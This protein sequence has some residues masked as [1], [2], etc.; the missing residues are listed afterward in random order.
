MFNN[1]LFESPN[2]FNTFIKKTRNNLLIIIDPP[3][4]GLVKLI[5]NTLN[6]IKEQFKND[7][8]ISILLFYPYFTENWICKWLPTLKMIDFKVSYNNHKKY[9]N[10][11][12][13]DDQKKGS[14]ARIFTNIEP[15][16]IDLK[17][18]DERSYY[19]CAD[20][21]K[22][23]FTINKHCFKCKKCP[24]KVI[25]NVLNVLSFY[26]LIFFLCFKDGGRYKHCD[27]CNRCFKNTFKH[28]LECNSC[29]LESTKDDDNINNKCCL[30]IELNQA[31]RIKLN[32]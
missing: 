1:H 16:K 19:F 4:G 18:V 8:D 6:N 26:F 2:H 21:Q 28:C 7:I 23:T 17:S 5:A 25:L 10:S 29:H 27:L 15:N 32:H 24:S 30:K 31:K 20:C 22:Y 13:N 12:S 3:Y 9:C 14:P 11:K